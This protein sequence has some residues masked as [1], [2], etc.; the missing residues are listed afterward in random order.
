MT[1]DHIPEWELAKDAA[2]IPD[3]DVDIVDPAVGAEGDEGS[4]TNG[5][6]T[7]ELRGTLN[8]TAGPRETE[9]KVNIPPLFQG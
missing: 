6:T 8:R 5:A 9:P 1:A 4:S 2:Q 7:V 3:T